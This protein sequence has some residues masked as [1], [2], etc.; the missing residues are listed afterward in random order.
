M[1]RHGYVLG[2]V[3]YYRILFVAFVVYYYTTL[4][5][6][7]Y[8]YIY[9]YIYIWNIY[10]WKC[11]KIAEEI[12][13]IYAAMRGGWMEAFKSFM[14]MMEYFMGTL[15]MHLIAARAGNSWL[16][17]RKPCYPPRCVFINAVNRDLYH[18]F[19]K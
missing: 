10:I 11:I 3:S 14:T 8:T 1:S 15:K 18:G 19:K 6:H 2:P 17:P 5:I 4:Y 16:F 12:D 7:I 9:T 13:L